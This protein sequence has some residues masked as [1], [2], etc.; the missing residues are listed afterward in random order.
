MI[1]TSNKIKYVSIKISTFCP[2]AIVTTEL[3][4]PVNVPHML[5]VH[6]DGL[7]TWYYGACSISVPSKDFTRAVCNRWTGSM[8][9]TTG[10][11]YWTDLTKYLAFLPMLAR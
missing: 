1:A 11:D 5:I 4:T 9:W 10:L 3:I 7:R 6:D 8:D 2:A